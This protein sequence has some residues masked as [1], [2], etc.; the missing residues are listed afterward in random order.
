MCTYLTPPR[1]GTYYFRMRVPDHLRPVIGQRE[2]YFSL[3]TKDPTEAKRRVIQVE[4][5]RHIALLEQ[6]EAAFAR[7]QHEAPVSAPPQLSAAEML[8]QQEQRKQEAR[9]AR[10]KS[11]EVE[12]RELRVR[13]TGNTEDMHPADAVIARAIQEAEAGEAMWRSIAEKALRATQ[14]G[15]G[16]PA[17][18][19]FLPAIGSS[20]GKPVANKPPVSLTGLFDDYAEKRL[21]PA[22]AKEWRTGIAKFVA[23]IGHD[24]ARLVTKEDVKR[25]RDH[26]AAEPQRNGKL[27]SPQRIN[28][29]YLAP[30]R[31]AFKHGV[32]ETSLDHN[33]AAI[34]GKLLVEK[35]V[36]T[37][38]RLLMREEWRT[39]LSASLKAE[40]DEGTSPYRQM[41]RRWIPWLC[42]YT[43]ARV[44]EITQLRAEDV[45]QVDGYW[46]MKVTR[47]KTR[48]FSNIPIHEHLVAQ[49]FLKFVEAQGK[50][51][52]FYDPEL[53]NAES[54][55]GQNVKVGQRLADWVRGLGVTDP[56]IMPNHAW[57][58]T[59][60]SLA[61]D[62]GMDERASNYITG[63][64]SVGVSRR[65]YTHH[66]HGPLAEQMAKF[67]RYDLAEPDPR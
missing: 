33:P 25:W 14:Q 30:L 65:T 57:R 27:R 45:Q 36:E 8:L 32:S 3:K 1:N 53:G 54:V 10:I 5:P 20:E 49:R 60:T 12:A 13:I 42:A 66:T 58:H 38:D 24:D 39:I 37:R 46:I 44:N 61:M 62:A 4:G 47:T 67:P 28:V 52:L 15:G 22:N 48:S 51:P 35:K 21:S 23:F 6:A 56:A 2:W 34:V 9:A 19:T 18:V 41:A 31:A 64:A 26:A 16:E 29:G 11:Q 63:H 40:T 7:Q 17:P 59:F 50:G 43:G 55:R